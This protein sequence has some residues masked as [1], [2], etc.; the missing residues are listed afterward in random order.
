MSK[1]WQ[2]KVHLLKVKQLASG[3]WNRL[4]LSLQA[5]VIAIICSS[6]ETSTDFG[7]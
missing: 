1:L 7:C 6:G 3:V 2:R 4:R 5:Y